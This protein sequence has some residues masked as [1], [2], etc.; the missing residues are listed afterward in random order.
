VAFAAPDL[1]VRWSARVKVRES[2]ARVLCGL[3]LYVWNRSPKFPGPP[4]PIVLSAN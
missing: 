4:E 1:G 2:L 3:D